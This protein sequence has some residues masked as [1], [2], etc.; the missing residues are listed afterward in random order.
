MVEAVYPWAVAGG[1][2]IAQ[3]IS[4]IYLSVPDCFHFLI[5]NFFSRILAIVLLLKE[6]VSDN[7]NRL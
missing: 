2:K 4:P 6:R 1:A 3:M 5:I 7:K